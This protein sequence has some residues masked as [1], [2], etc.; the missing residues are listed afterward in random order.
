MVLVNFELVKSSST[1]FVELHVISGVLCENMLSVTNFQVV[2]VVQILLNSQVH[3]SI[4]EQINGD[5][6]RSYKKMDFNYAQN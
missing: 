1:Y 6:Y 5:E 4:V 2:I 3:E